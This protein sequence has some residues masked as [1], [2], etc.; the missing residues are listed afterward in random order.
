M[1]KFHLEY[2]QHVIIM[3]KA[4]STPTSAPG[5]QL[6]I[7]QQMNPTIQQNSQVLSSGESMLQLH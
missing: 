4:Q 1:W 2:F 5:L 3:T 7:A 6:P